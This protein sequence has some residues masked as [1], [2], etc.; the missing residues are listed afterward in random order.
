MTRPAV[1][2]FSTGDVCCVAAAPTVACTGTISD[3]DIIH[4]TDLFCS[5]ITTSASAPGSK[6]QL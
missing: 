5:S 4:L 2:L 3:L 1:N 6:M